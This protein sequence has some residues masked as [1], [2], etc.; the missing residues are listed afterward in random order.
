[1]TEAVLPQLLPG[2]RILVCRPQADAESLARTLQATGA[3]VHSLPCLEIVPLEL[4]DTQRQT[5]LNLDQYA[6]IIVTSQYAAQYGLDLIDTYWPQLPAQQQWHA[7]GRKTA[8][9]LSAGGVPLQQPNGDLD[10]EQL[11]QSDTLQNVVEKKIL[12]LKGRKGREQLQQT[13]RNR[14][15]RVETLELY[16]RIAPTYSDA[17]LQEALAQFKPE[18]AVCLSAETVQNLQSYAHKIGYAIEQVRL[19]VPSARVAQVAKSCGFKLTYVT[20]NLM[21]IDIIRCLKAAR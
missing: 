12:L 4:D 10:S 3:A 16:E 7:I 13:L 9:A 5:I 19:I 17:T 1:M 15:A 18:W 21:P 14:S 6:H 20:E 11:L 8:Q 2:E